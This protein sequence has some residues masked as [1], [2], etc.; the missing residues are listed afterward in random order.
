[1]IVHSST[2]SSDEEI[3]LPARAALR[4]LVV[5]VAIA[6]VV[7]GALELGWRKLGFAPMP[8]DTLQL[9]ALEREQV[10][11]SAREVAI[12]GSSRAQ[13]GLDPRIL[14]RELGRPVHQLAITGGSPIPVLRDLAADDDFHGL[15]IC[16]VTPSAFFIRPTEI[17]RQSGA[18]WA[19]G[20]H[21]LPWLSSFETRLRVALQARSSLLLPQTNVRFQMSA[22][23]VDRA[24]ARPA[25]AR[26]RSDRYRGARYTHEDRAKIMAH[27]A[28]GLR[29]SKPPSDGELHELFTEIQGWVGKIRARG[30]DVVFVRIVSSGT[31]FDTEQELWPRERFWDLFVA[32]FDAHAIYFA[33]EPTLIGFTAP[34]GSH[35]DAPQA[36]RFSHALGQV[37]HAHGWSR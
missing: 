31:V 14:Q 5:A 1:M 35:L 18:D 17:D 25:V 12:I 6:V 19:A 28:K 10:R 33:D 22:L 8:R 15:V 36:T 9:W 11:G 34:E 30:G 29:A 3:A 37:I 16:E 23:L 27:W 24:F 32:S 26:E 21:T 2:S 4:P 7:L 13:L 20:W